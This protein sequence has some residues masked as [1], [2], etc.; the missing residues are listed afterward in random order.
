MT[1][2]IQTFDYS[3]NV[4]Q[5]LLWQYNEALRLQSLLLSK[6]AWYAQNQTQFWEDFYNNIFN[7]DTAN[8]FGLSVWA[9]ILGQPIVFNNS[10]NPG[11]NPFGFGVN[12]ENFTHGNFSQGDGNTYALPTAAARILLQLRYFQLTSSGTVPETNRML[13]KVFGAFGNAWLIDNHDM[14]QTYVF[15]F[16]LTAELVYL[17]RNTDIL[18]RPAGVA[19]T[20]QVV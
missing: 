5:A 11:Q 18:P 19:S 1:E 9:I 17:F 14:T 8:Y 2:T 15:D 7:L 4:Q 20:Y 10:S 12:N 16:P 3:V 13:K 6:Q